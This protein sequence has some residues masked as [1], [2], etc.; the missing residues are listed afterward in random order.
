[1]LKKETAAEQHA[2]SGKYVS[3]RSDLVYSKIRPYLKKAIL[4]DFEGLCSADMYPLKPAADVSAGF[5]LAAI[6]G[7]HFAKYT[8]SVSVR[9]GMPKI[10]RA[11]LAEYTMAFRPPKPNKKP[12]PRR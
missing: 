9:S 1:M 6:L 2:I 3:L 7:H 12:S 5:I 10:N 4:A 11:E 8:E